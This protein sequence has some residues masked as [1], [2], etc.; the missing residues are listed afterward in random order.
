MQLSDGS[1]EPNWSE[2]TVLVDA[3][4][5]LIYESDANEGRPAVTRRTH[6]AGT[7]WYV[8]ADL[9]QQTVNNSV[10]QLAGETGLQRV[11]EAQA[12]IEVT[13]RGN[14]GGSAIPLPN[15]LH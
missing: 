14:R 4:P 13:R 5:V 10:T 7:A 12:G 1:T 15:Q 11:I 3:E 9:A 2:D 8:S 6:G